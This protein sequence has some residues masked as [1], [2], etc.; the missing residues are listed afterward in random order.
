[1]EQSKI[2][3]HDRHQRLVAEEEGFSGPFPE[4]FTCLHCHT[5]GQAKTA[6]NAKACIECHQ[7]DPG[8]ERASDGNANLALAASYLGAMHGT[9]IDCHKEKALELDRP[10]LQDCSTCHQSLGPRSVSGQHVLA[11]GH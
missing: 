8:W 10:E 4:N 2:F 5:E 11:S 9:C 7:K 1:V 3:D 6:D